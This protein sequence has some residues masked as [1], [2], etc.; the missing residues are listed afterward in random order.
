M[1]WGAD[2]I[3]KQ[4]VAILDRIY[5]HAIGKRTHSTESRYTY[6]IDDGKGQEVSDA[7][8]AYDAHFNGA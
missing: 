8:L 6:D 2:N 4:A 7:F 5:C 1:P 3:E